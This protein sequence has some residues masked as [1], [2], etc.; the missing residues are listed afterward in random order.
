[1]AKVAL[2]IGVTDYKIEGSNLGFTNLPSAKLDVEGMKR[3]LESPD[4]GAFDEVESLLNP[5][6]SEMSGAIEDFLGK[7][8]K[9]DTVLLY[10]SGHG[11]KDGKRRLYFAAKGTVKN[12]KD[13]LKITT[14][15][16]SQVV[17]EQLEDCKAT[18][19]IMILDCC[20]SGAIDPNA[21][22]DDTSEVLESSLSEAKGSI[23]LT[24]SSSTEISYGDATQMSFYTRYL[25]QGVESGEADRDAN[26]QLSI[27]ELHAYV[28]AKLRVE[29]AT[30]NPKVFLPREEG[31]Y[32]APFISVPIT[33]PRQA[34]R[35]KV[36]DYIDRGL[37]KQGKFDFN[38][39][40]VLKSDRDQINQVSKSELSLDDAKAIENELL[41]PIL[42]RLKNLSDYRKAF[43]EHLET[44]TLDQS[45]Q[46]LKLWRENVLK[47]TDADVAEIE[48]EE[49][50]RQEQLKREAAEQQRQAEEEE[51]QR[52]Q[53]EQLRQQ[54]AAEAD[55]LKG[56]YAH[57]EALLKAENWQEAD[58]ETVKQ[59]CQ[60][61]G[62]QQ[63]GYL[64]VEDA[65][66]F[67]GADM[68]AIDQLWVKYSNGKFGFSVQKEIWQQCNTPTS[69]DLE[70][71]GKEVMWL[72]F[73]NEWKWKIYRELTWDISAPKGHLPSWRGLTTGRR[74]EGLA[75]VGSGIWARWADGEGFPGERMEALL[76]RIAA[77]AEKGN[78][79]HLE[80]LLKAGNWQEADQ[81]TFK[82]MCQ[83]MGRQ[84]EGYLKVEDI[85][86]FPCADMR[87]IDQLWVRYSNG[88]FGFSV[89]KKIWQGCGSPTEY[90]KQWEKFGIEVGWR[91]KGMMGRGASWKGCGDLAFTVGAPVGHL[92]WRVG[93]GDWVVRGEVGE[94]GVEVEWCSLFSRVRRCKL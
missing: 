65:E 81:E 62:R 54:Q 80:A 57:L 6:Y 4:L 42:Q 77:E 58:Q 22:G 12:E 55:R 25:V 73:V 34:Y 46:S 48:Q 14:A 7:P 3:I 50:Q 93:F 49:R 17:S 31:F 24:S 8:Q 28:T 82:Q 51:R 33:D 5:T 88:K 41:H 89:Q 91:S 30:M 85:E 29:K 70:K 10:F 11:A 36:K 43:R 90:N 38:M 94:V 61:M 79:A 9:N 45:H 13:Q 63:E 16:S 75:F 71:F 76:S 64:K 92:P 53:S 20:F 35:K 59:M 26:G 87:A 39:E 83:V 19:K 2:L 37:A 74:H 21:K 40:Q 18:K 67:P 78:Y 72:K 32:N 68:R 52:W 60:I 86:Q 23:I 69:F 66:Q 15:V 1:M 56:N 84:Q 27:S 44:Q 47:L